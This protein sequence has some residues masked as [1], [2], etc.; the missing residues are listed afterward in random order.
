MN[1]KMNVHHSSII[2]NAIYNMCTGRSAYFVK[3]KKNLSNYPVYI[4]IQQWT[5]KYIQYVCDGFYQ[6]A[7]GEEISES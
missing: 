6:G 5:T 4:Y 7:E 1:K 2:L 3:K